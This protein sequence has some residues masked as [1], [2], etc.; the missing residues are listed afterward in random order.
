MLRWSK[1]E[2]ARGV[3]ISGDVNL[4]EGDSSIEAGGD[5]VLMYISV[6]VRAMVCGAVAVVSCWG[7]YGLPAAVVYL[8]CCPDVRTPQLTFF[9]N[10]DV[11]RELTEVDFWPSLD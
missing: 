2:D 6:T 3:T 11:V 1:I 9:F 4:L 7:T 10:L 8:V 5:E